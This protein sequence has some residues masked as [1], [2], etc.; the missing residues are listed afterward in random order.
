M[1]ALPLQVLITGLAAGGVY[2]IVAIAYSLIYRLMGVIHF[3][4]GELLALALFA[5]LFFAAG[6]GA[7]SRTSVSGPRF[8]LA[9]LGGTAVAVV[10]GVLVYALAVRPFLWRRRSLGWIAGTVAVAFAVRGFLAAAFVRGS[11]VFPDPLRLDR[12]PN[13][14]VLSLG[15]GVTLHVR[16]FVVLAVGIA[17]AAVMN[18]LMSTSF[19]RALQAIASSRTGARVVGLPIDLLLAAVF[20]VAGA[21]ATI[22]AVA[23]APSAPISVQTG[24]LLGLKGLVAALLVRFGSP[25]RAFAGGLA[26]GVLE[27]A[28]ANLHVG[29]VRLGPQYRDV[30]PLV[31][32]IV[33]IAAQRRST[34]GDAAD[35]DETA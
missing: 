16:T 4:I 3:A 8:A 10:S 31:L 34:A 32:A 13:G 6:T 26:L 23:Q 30:I 5:T 19:G 20:A 21:V 17:L 27:A 33:I 2:G 9:L 15:G 14:G 7:V 11:Y 25:L 28:V 1:W 22:A 12:L 24:A 29:G 18:W 35:A